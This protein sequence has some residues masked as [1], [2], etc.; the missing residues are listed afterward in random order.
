MNGPDFVFICDTPRFSAMIII[1]TTSVMKPF[2]YDMPS[3]IG[4]AASSHTTPRPLHDKHILGGILPFIHSL[5]R[6]HN[7]FYLSRFFGRLPNG[8]FFPHVFIIDV[9]LVC[10]AYCP[11]QHSHLSAVANSGTLFITF[12]QLSQASCTN[13]ILTYSIVLRQLLKNLSPNMHIQDALD[14]IVA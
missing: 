12:P 7:I 9:V 6:G 3:F 8:G 4:L 10:I 1:W 2:T 11:S 13:S 14:F 5:K